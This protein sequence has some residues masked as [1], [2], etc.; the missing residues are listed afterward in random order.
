MD[1]PERTVR[2][3]PQALDVLCRTTNF[4]R[5]E[6]QRM[7]RGFKQE[8]PS[9]IVNEET[10]K[11]IYCQFFPLGN[12]NRYAHYVF[13]TF[14]QNQNGADILA[15]LSSLSRGT[16]Q[17]KIGWA[18][19]LYDVDGDGYVRRDEM[20]AIVSS[21]YDL[22]ERYAVR[23]PNEKTVRDHVDRIFQRMLG[24]N[25][26]EVDKN[27]TDEIL[28]V[29]NR[30]PG[31]AVA[32][33][34]FN[35]QPCLLLIAAKGK[36][37]NKAALYPV[38]V[39]SKFS[40]KCHVEG[41]IKTTRKIGIENE[42]KYTNLKITKPATGCVLVF[43]LS[44]N[45]MSSRIESSTFDV[46]PKDLVLTIS[47][48]IAK[49]NNESNS[50]NLSF[51]FDITHFPWLY[52]VSF[53]QPLSHVSTNT[54]VSSCSANFSQLPVHVTGCFLSDWGYRY[55]LRVKIESN[56]SSW[57]LI[58]YSAPFDAFASKSLTIEGE[59][60][61][62][63]ARL[64]GKVSLSPS[65]EEREQILANALNQLGVKFPNLQWTN[66]FLNDS[67]KV[68]NERKEFT[69]Q[70]NVR[71]F[72]QEVRQLCT[73]I[74]FKKV[75]WKTFEWTVHEP[76]TISNQTECPDLTSSEAPM[77]KT[78][79]SPFPWKTA[80]LL[81][82]V[83]ILLFPVCV[84]MCIWPRREREIQEKYQERLS[85]YQLTPEIKHHEFKGEDNVAFQN[86]R[87]SNTT[88]AVNNS[89]PNGVANGIPNGSSIKRKTD[90]VQLKAAHLT[91][92]HNVPDLFSSSES[93]IE[94]PQRIHLLRSRPPSKPTVVSPVTAQYATVDAPSPDD[95]IENLARDILGTPITTSDTQKGLTAPIVT[96]FVKFRSSTER[97][98]SCV[99]IS[100]FAN[101]IKTNGND[102]HN[103]ETTLPEP[104]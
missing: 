2:F 17:D 91:D 54:S 26:T 14:D 32:G 33:K 60:H 6:I 10:F 61:T 55:R 28:L 3:R 84:L 46:F 49:N 24:E 52:T 21:V 31:N 22:M 67:D 89:V 20:V 39:S 72:F 92:E 78:S 86:D 42:C 95:S 1:P 40:E 18:F 83:G 27:A 8:C 96:S 81:I 41:T 16:L 76:I 29:L 104:Q 87:N 102:R 68:K 71:G 69:L 62:V 77:A 74:G 90:F 43:T 58:S 11:Q 34:P 85:R 36:S 73:K 88:T 75:L 59:D 4:S 56:T 35:V 19:R 65:E 93:S 100:S 38:V 23:A 44:A 9:G 12:A 103:A 64:V 30:Q 70:W 80:G 99:S 25:E 97:I 51:S 53:H 5:R 63:T 7:Y 47:P 13:K 45:G 50:F 37:P 66:G 15:C 82:L 98:G 101:P 57:N 94:G 48:V 79:P